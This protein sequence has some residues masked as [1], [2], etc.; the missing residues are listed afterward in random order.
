VAE[1]FCDYLNVTFPPDESPRVKVEDLLSAIGGVRW[2]DTTGAST[3]AFPGSTGKAKYHER[4]AWAGVSLSGGVCGLLRASG[5]WLDMLSECAAG[6]H[7]VSRLDLAL[8]VPIAGSR[9][10][11]ALWRRYPSTVKLTRKAVKT[12]VLLAVGPDGRKTGTFYAGNSHRGSAKVT[13]AVYDK[14]L[15]SED[16]RF[17]II[18]PTTRYEIRIK[19]DS[20]APGVGVTLRDAAICDPAFYHYASPALLRRPPGIPDWIPGSD[21]DWHYEV[22]GL[23]PLAR[24]QRSVWR[25]PE[26]NR[27]LELADSVPNGREFLVRELGRRIASVPPAG[28]SVRPPA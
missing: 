18:E 2:D 17:E 25:F 19:K 27:W 11:P 22:P 1:A 9:V 4:R 3:W 5:L 26:V 8:D 28:A 10:I 23:D 12:S 20:V 7:R 14:A 6:P 15:E 16:K 21:M 13:A 24:L